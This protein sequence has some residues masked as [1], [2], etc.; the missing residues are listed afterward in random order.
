MSATTDYR[1]TG[2]TCEHCVHAVTAE[3]SAL[4]AVTGVSIDLVPGGASTV[5]VA[6][7]TP[8]DLAR[9]REAIEE[10]GYALAP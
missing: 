1:V 8:L 9:V 10:A 6:A 5:R 2:M 7:D 3:V 4:P